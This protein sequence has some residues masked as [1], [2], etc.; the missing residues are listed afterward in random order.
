MPIWGSRRHVRPGEVVFLMAGLHFTPLT[1][2]PSGPRR[3]R[4][5]R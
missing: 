3:I 2:C 1:P 5:A 4:M